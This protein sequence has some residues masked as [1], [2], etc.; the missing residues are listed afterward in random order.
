MTIP[1]TTQPQPIA[2]GN[3][4]NMTAAFMSSRWCVRHAREPIAA[5]AAISNIK[6]YESI[7]M[8]WDTTRNGRKGYVRIIASMSRYE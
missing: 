5:V 3:I 7:T 4:Q 6:G 1:D 2:E 8:D